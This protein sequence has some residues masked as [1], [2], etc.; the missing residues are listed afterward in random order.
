MP[1]QPQYFPVH[2]GQGLD[3]KTDPKL[4]IPGK[5]LRLENG[6]FTSPGRLTKRNGYDAMSVNK[7]GGGAMTAPKMF[8]AYKDQAVVADAGRLRSYD[9]AL[10][11]W[12]DQGKY[13]PVA[14]TNKVVSG[15]NGPNIG[16]TKTQFNGASDGTHVVY[17]WSNSGPY[18]S[19]FE[20]ATGMQAAPDT[21]LDPT[22]GSN[23]RPTVVMLSTGY[24]AILYITGINEVRCLT[25]DCTGSTIS[26]G[27]GSVIA[28][29]V[30]T[31]PAICAVS[32]NGAGAVIAYSSDNAAGGGAPAR[33]KLI[34]LNA[35]GTVVTSATAITTGGFTAAVPFS[36]N[37][38]SATGNTWVY[39][40][41]NTTGTTCYYGIVNSTLVT[42][43]A[44][45]SIA[46]PATATFQICAIKVTTTQQKVYI[47]GG[48]TTAAA[49][50]I[51]QRTVTSGG[52]VG[53]SSLFVAGLDLY[54]VPFTV[55][56]YTTASYLA[57]VFLSTTQATLFILDIADAA[58][59]AKALV[60]K[61]EGARPAGDLV[62]ASVNSA[63]VILPAGYINVFFGTPGAPSTI[64]TII[65]GVNVGLDF[66]P[67]EGFQTQIA[68]DA[69]V[70]NGGI[71]SMF[72]GQS[73]VEL[74]FH[75]APEI[76]SL[77]AG[78]VGSGTHLSDG[79]Y[80][81]ILIYQWFDANGNLH[82][83]GQSV[84]VSVTLSA[85][86][87][88]Q[89]VTIVFRNYAFTQKASTRGIVY[90]H[91]YRTLVNGTAFHYVQTHA[92]DTTAATQSQPDQT[93][94]AGL[95]S[96][97]YST[98]FPY[99]FGGILSNAAPPAA[100]IMQTK[101]GRLWVMDSENP[102]TSYMSKPYVPGAGLA[103]CAELS[104]QIDEVGG[105]TVTMLALD[106]KM[107]FVKEKPQ[108]YYLTG[109]G[110]NDTGNNST[111]S[112]PTPVPTDVGAS[113]HKGSIVMPMGAMIKTPK[114]IYL[115]NRSIQVQYIGKDVEAYNSQSITEATLLKTKNQVRF[116]TSSGSTLL[117]DYAV[118]QWGIFTNHLGYSADIYSGNYTY[119]RTDG[120]IY[121]ENTTG[122]YLDNA[123]GFAL[124]AQTTYLSF[125]GVQGFERVKRLAWLGD[126]INGS[127]ASHGMQVSA[128]Y[129]F[130]TTFGTAT[131]YYPGV[132]SASG[133]LNYQQFLTQ[134]KC[135]TLSL[136]IEELVTN[137][138]G[139]YLDLTD[140][141]LEVG[142]KSGRNRMP[143]A[144]LVG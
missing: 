102:N 121:Q 27:S 36:I 39:C 35:T 28:T 10:A 141:T 76:N 18:A 63:N 104:T 108:I 9:S 26:L 1:L 123:T 135:D 93:S 101:N 87:A 107:I 69:L 77:T 91:V 103:F 53:A 30:S 75:I 31:V 94:D 7:F 143:A 44:L 133:V 90:T 19:V 3:T 88:D 15:G 125:A 83:S 22:A 29:D 6:I 38:D 81:Y 119:A 32:L 84:P 131:P 142:V 111:L 99:T 113:S 4:V 105:K 92:N 95:V 58:V 144:Q 66:N 17:A 46:A 41:N 114:G 23:C 50:T 96:G 14:V 20:E 106:D 140:L 124:K 13:V 86:T 43:L 54:S 16:G 64:S 137:A 5:Y 79:V 61:S 110:P 78:V 73:A 85:G 21:A 48:P 98:P 97:A 74:G 12:K 116:L 8:R 25:V 52:S 40:R 57:C 56:G 100:M 89:Y 49:D 59:V 68:G 37:Y 72:D 128:A 24:F 82:Q 136:L 62:A 71:L 112:L 132:A 117:Y 34:T 122:T 60:N 42:Q 67:S 127:S 33:V 2:F 55:A 138:S 47:S 129:D 115:L 118:Q 130:S 139:E 134:Q 126:Y 45:T 65:G 120:A 109:D 51:Y 70:L 11:R 80:Q